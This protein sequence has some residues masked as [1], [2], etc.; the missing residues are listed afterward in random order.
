MV[1]LGA[2]LGPL[3]GSVN[4]AFPA[5]IERFAL[6][7]ADIQWIIIPFI[8]AQSCCALV[9]GKLGDLYGHRRVFQVGLACAALAHLACGFATTY[10]M[11]VG[12]RIAQGV[13]VGIAIACAPALATL[14]FPPEQK[15]RVLALYLML[16]GIGFVLGPIAG[17]FVLAAAGWPGV[18]WFRV[19]IALAALALS[20]GLPAPAHERTHRPRLDFGG[21]LLLTIAL[22]SLVLASSL[23]RTGA[24][25]FALTLALAGVAASIAFVRHEAAFA[26]PILR[27]ATF[28]E[29]GFAALQGAAVAI[30]LASFAIFLLM[31]FALATRAGYSALGSGALLALHPAGAILV[32]AYVGWRGGGIASLVLVRAGMFLAAAGIAAVGG[33]IALE[34]SL[35]LI[36]ATFFV[37][38]L[39]LGLFQIGY[40][41]AT[42]SM[43]PLADRGV[44]G[45]L[46][47]VTRLV[48]LVFGATGILGLHQAAGD[49]YA[50]T[51]AL[52]GGALA[53]F[54]LGIES[55]L[56]T[57]RDP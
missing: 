46:V 10:P 49:D 32:N 31:P 52:C 39:G 36:G 30:N 51:F 13:A 53:L 26:E 2:L 50:W 4:V 5:I 20:L 1:F 6:S 19:P 56:R 55:S 14:M 43:L 44:A 33:A 48:G 21:A 37:A 42:T 34:A 17:G 11:L 12:M 47:N 35:A 40:T 54:A 18:F 41:D 27:V 57:R 23:A 16:L 9:A 24:L 38:G 25:A 15:R 7:I 8:I 22:A 45:S 3:D 28:R 29:R